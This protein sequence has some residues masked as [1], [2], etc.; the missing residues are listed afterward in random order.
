MRFALPLLLTIAVTLTAATP[1]PPPA[2]DVT[3]CCPS[4]DNRS[5][6]GTLIDGV[7]TSTELCCG[8]SDGTTCCYAL[9][10]SLLTPG[11]SC[12]AFLFTC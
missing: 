7:L 1:A 3:L 9:T 8:Y 2:P 12:I 10:G 11:N 6:T 4:I 5:P